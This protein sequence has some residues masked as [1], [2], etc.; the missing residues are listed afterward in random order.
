MAD[1]ELTQKYNTDF[2]QTQKLQS[3][4]VSDQKIERTTYP[5]LEQPYGKQ[6]MP[7]KAVSSY[8]LG[9]N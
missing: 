3:P 2:Q 6:L 8:Q 1:F 7:S 5:C 4:Y 9:E